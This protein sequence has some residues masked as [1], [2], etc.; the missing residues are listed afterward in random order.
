[1]CIRDRSYQEI[2]PRSQKNVTASVTL[3]SVHDSVEDIIVDTNQVRPGLYVG[4]NLL[5]PEHRNVKVCV[6]NTTTQPQSITPGSCLGN[7]TTVTLVTGD[8]SDSDPPTTPIASIDAEKSIDEIIEPVLKSL[9]TVITD[10]QRQRV[11]GLLR[12]YD[13]LFSRSTFDMG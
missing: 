5:P 12:S 8:G 1:M 4:R 7:A 3:Q 2:P 13:N 10:D 9:P 11:T 6:V